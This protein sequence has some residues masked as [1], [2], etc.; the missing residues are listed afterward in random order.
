MTTAEYCIGTLA[1][2][3]FGAI[4]YKLLSSN[5]A[6]DIVKGVIGQALKLLHL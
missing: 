3:A 5:W 4:L 2:C 6:Y 1:A